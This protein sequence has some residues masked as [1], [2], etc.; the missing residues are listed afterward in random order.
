MRLHNVYFFDFFRISKSES[1]DTVF[2]NEE[3]V[4]LKPKVPDARVT[5]TET[6]KRTEDG[7]QKALKEDKVED[8]N[9]QNLGFVRLIQRP[10]SATRSLISHCLVSDKLRSKQNKL[11]SQNNRVQTL[12]SYV[13]ELLGRKE[14]KFTEINFNPIN[15][16][17]VPT[18]KVPTIE[19][20][21]ELKDNS[22][23]KGQETGQEGNLDINSGPENTIQ[24][25]LG[26]QTVER[27]ENGQRI[28]DDG[29]QVSNGDSTEIQDGGSEVEKSKK[30]DVIPENEDVNRKQEEKVKYNISFSKSISVISRAN[31][32]CKS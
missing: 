16:G 22:L 8:K 7:T 24:A 6:D 18:V 10:R 2:D 17:N 12:C 23:K 30:S 20:G 1:T 15:I 27:T 4:K 21:T 13:N 9:G 28:L 14:R 26:G 31:A 11:E 29:Q 5:E 32:S 19:V 3:K 25:G